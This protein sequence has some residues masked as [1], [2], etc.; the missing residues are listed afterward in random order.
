MKEKYQ[1]LIEE[2]QYQYDNSQ[3]NE[4]RM[5]SYISGEEVKSIKRT[6]SINDITKSN[7]LNED[8]SLRIS[9]N[10]NKINENTCT[11]TNSDTNNEYDFSK[12]AIDD[13]SDKKEEIE[14]LLIAKDLK[15]FDF[16]K[17]L[18]S[19]AFPT[20]LFYLF[21]I[22]MQTINLVFIRI[23][24]DNNEMGQSIGASN[25]YIN[26]TLFAVLMGLISGI[27]TLCANAFAVKKYYLMGLYFQR[28]RIITYGVCIIIVIIHI[29]TAKYVIDLFDL[30]ESVKRDAVTY[31]YYS[32]IYVFFD[33]QSA[34]ILRYLN[35]TRKAHI[36]FIIL[37]ICILLHPL[38]NVIFINWLD[39]G[40]IGSAL[41]FIT[42]RFLQCVLL[43]MY[44]WIYPPVPEA[45]FWLNRKCFLGLYDYFKFSLGSLILM[46]AEWWPFEIL[47]YLSTK[48]SYL[49]YNVH[50]YAAQLNSLLFSL[51]IGIGFAT[52]IYISEYI[53]KHSVKVTKKAAKICLTYAIILAGIL[54]LIVFCLRGIILQLFTTDKDIL[55]KGQN[56]MLILSFSTFLDCCQ[57]TLSSILR[58]LGK[59]SQAS[60]MTVIQFYI[61]MMSLAYVFGIVL[62]MGVLGIWIAILI[63]N[64]I[65]FCLYLFMLTCIINWDDVKEDTIKRL[66][67]DNK[68]ILIED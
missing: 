22:L 37:F 58:G 27:D 6:K 4:D 50:I 57:Y 18:N 43:T 33:V 47:T 66:N 10:K 42:G 1:N 68:V 38:W 24:Y 2:N 48:M 14:I 62:N 5:F 60:I 49:D 16:V 17:K 30:K 51:A 59:Q 13:N 52:T 35:V 54:S 56:I 8:F 44:I 55:E 11:L 21:V 31:L 34:I 9:N 63:G 36:S 7:D 40:I 3:D 29:F 15:F 12:T 23:K 25:L 45:S 46:C 65:A 32:L 67:N 26:C 19:I 28:A 39:M 61:V 53:A 41:A 64:F 20:L